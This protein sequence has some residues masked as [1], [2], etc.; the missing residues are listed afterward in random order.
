[1]NIKTA[2][3]KTSCHKLIMTWCDRG[4][5]PWILDKRFSHEWTVRDLKISATKN[6]PRFSLRSWRDLKSHKDSG[7]DSYQDPGEISKSRRPKTR[8]DSRWDSRR[9]LGEISKSRQQKAKFRTEEVIFKSKPWAEPTREYLL[10]PALQRSRLRG[11]RAFLSVDWHSH[12]A[13]QQTVF[14]WQNHMFQ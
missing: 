2:W 13:T 12:K 14:C 5:Q 6:S 7:R 4:Q 1:M 3:Y 11:T 10:A 9:D 8:R